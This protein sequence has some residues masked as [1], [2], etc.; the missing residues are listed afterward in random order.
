MKRWPPRKHLQL[1]I[2][3]DESLFVHEEATRPKQLFLFPG[4]KEKG[5]R[6]TLRYT[7]KKYG[8]SEIEHVQEHLMPKPTTVD[9]VFNFERLYHSHELSIEQICLGLWRLF[10]LYNLNDA[11]MSELIE[12]VRHSLERKKGTNMPSQLLALAVLNLVDSRLQKNT[13]SRYFKTKYLPDLSMGRRSYAARLLRKHGYIVENGS[14]W[15]RT[16]KEFDEK[17][18]WLKTKDGEKVSLII[19][20]VSPQTCITYS[21]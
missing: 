10:P 16:D 14:G 11:K 7:V 1:S 17:D 9:L 5:C 20:C 8:G 13:S 19:L 6:K 3:E 21:L 15:Y 2:D 4:K 12:K 18:F